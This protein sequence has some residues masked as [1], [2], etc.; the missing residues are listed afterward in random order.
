MI[1]IIAIKISRPNNLDHTIC[2]TFLFFIKTFL[3][4]KHNDRKTA[5]THKAIKLTRITFKSYNKQFVQFKQ[6]IFMNNE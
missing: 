1:S 4:N 5:H 2:K 6:Y 3:Y